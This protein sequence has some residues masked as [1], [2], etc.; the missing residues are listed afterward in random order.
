ML[1]AALLILMVSDK[2]VCTK[3]T[4]GQLWPLVANEDKSALLTFARA[5]SLEMC[6]ASTWGYKWQRLT[7]NIHRKGE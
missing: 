6:M 7:V 4:Q 3:K 1:S 5:G 2:P